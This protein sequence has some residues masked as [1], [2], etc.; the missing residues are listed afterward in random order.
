[1]STPTTF[2][3]YG[4]DEP[5]PQYL[6]LMGVFGAFFT[7]LCASESRRSRGRHGTALDA[8]AFVI[9]AHKLS[10]LLARDRVTAPLRAPFAKF[11]KDAGA[12]ELEE[13]SRGEGMQKAI[14]NLVTCPYCIAPWVACGMMLAARLAP[15]PTRML[16][17]L[18]SV[19]A[20]SDFL[21]RVYARLES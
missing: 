12:G 15:Q 19:V 14:G 7:L 10:R 8:L 2:S 11:E 18:M 4:S 1:M 5:L 6:G 16:S 9:A 20:V 3:A 17:R 13:Q 21:N